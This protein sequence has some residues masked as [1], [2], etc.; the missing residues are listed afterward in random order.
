MNVWRDG[1]SA[2]YSRDSEWRGS[3]E[4]LRTRRR[5]YFTHLVELVAFLA[6]YTNAGPDEAPH[7]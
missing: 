2:S 6:A 3:V 7:V 4:H 1:S 5:L